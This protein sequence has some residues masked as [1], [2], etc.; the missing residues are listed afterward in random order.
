[1]YVC[2]G[3]GV[4]RISSVPKSVLRLKVNKGQVKIPLPYTKGA[5]FPLLL[6]STLNLIFKLHTK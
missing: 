5:L 6:L 1:M 3:N 2:N 4:D